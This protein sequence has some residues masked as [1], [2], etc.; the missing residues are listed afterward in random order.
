MLFN[1]ADEA[2]YLNAT[3]DHWQLRHPWLQSQRPPCLPSQSDSNSTSEALTS[4]VPAADKF[5]SC[6]RSYFQLG[7]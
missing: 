6:G 3:H 5:C 2:E 1:V 7:D 4:L